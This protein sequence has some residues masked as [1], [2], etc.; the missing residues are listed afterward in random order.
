MAT[1]IKYNPT[2]TY[3]DPSL[4]RIQR[5]IEQMRKNTY[6]QY[7]NQLQNQKDS[8]NSWQQLPYQTEDWLQQYLP[9]ID[10]AYQNAFNK[11]GN[12]PGF[13]TSTKTPSTFLTGDANAWLNFYKD[14]TTPTGPGLLEYSAMLKSTLPSTYDALNDPNLT[15]EQRAN[16]Y[17]MERMGQYGDFLEGRLPNLQELLSQNTDIVEWA[18]QNFGYDPFQTAQTASDFYT[19]NAAE[20]PEAMKGWYDSYA[21]SLQDWLTQSS[22]LVTDGF[23]QAIDR[24][25]GN[26][27]QAWQWY[28]AHAPNDTDAKLKELMGQQSDYRSSLYSQ[29]AQ[30]VAAQQQQAIADY[31]AQARAA[32]RP[33]DPS[34]VEAIKAQFSQQLS[35][36]QSQ[37]EGQFATQQNE[38]LQAIGANQSNYDQ[39]GRALASYLAQAMQNTGQSNAASLANAL[40]SLAGITQGS[41]GG[42]A[43]VALQ[44]TGNNLTATN[45][46]IRNLG[47]WAT[48]QTGLQQT[49]LQN[50][51]NGL[52]ANTQ[53]QM[54]NSN[55]QFQNVLNTLA[56]MSL[57]GSINRDATLQN[58]IGNLFQNA[59]TLSG[60]RDL[61]IQSIANQLAN[62]G[63]ASKQAAQASGLRQKE[64][65]T[66]AKLQDQ[67]SGRE[68]QREL[69]RLAA[70]DTSGNL[71]TALNSLFQSQVL[72]L[73][74]ADAA[75]NQ[76]IQIPDDLGFAERYEQMRQNLIDK[77][78]NARTMNEM[79]QAFRE[80]A[81]NLQ[82]LQSTAKSQQQQQKKN[83]QSNQ[84][85]SV[86]NY[87][88]R[89][90][91]I[92]D[93]F[94]KDNA[95]SLANAERILKGVTENRN[96]Q[97]DTLPM[98]PGNNYG[99][100]ML[101]FPSDYVESSPFTLPVEQTTPT[102]DFA[103]SSTQDSLSLQIPGA[104]LPTV[105]SIVDWAQLSK[106]IQEMNNQ[107]SQ[108]TTVLQSGI[109][110]DD[111]FRNLLNFLPR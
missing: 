35:Q 97:Q 65:E 46:Y 51:I 18:K 5:A 63:I 1:E 11:V 100:D 25:G 74:G 24:F 89:A 60:Q 107:N 77:Y 43:N 4:A 9:Y 20:V 56:Q 45:D 106:V 33:V 110:L 75:R 10:S 66:Q 96:T 98:E 104:Y 83:V 16:L 57:G 44:T 6:T 58:Q 69:Q 102:L 55:N 70:T 59:Q 64:M 36:A 15:P 87:Q 62:A 84:N 72:G 52:A 103:P 76:P 92:Y 19:R 90:N 94:R 13:Q 22:G 99:F 2:T 86:T 80:Y 95:E 79:T 3:Q 12:M 17:D 67:L 111:T 105:G 109:A 101:G 91:K 71:Q 50:L 7:Q 41:L 37:L 93:V 30:R 28:Q 88:N 14:G 34:E 85:S 26:I 29:L 47:S 42:L 108:P 27:D 31:Q 8:I 54:V 78:Q 81:E 23:Q 48:Q 38:W 68:L 39:T 82:K 49:S 40:A 53:N 73:Q 32:G 61:S 21:K